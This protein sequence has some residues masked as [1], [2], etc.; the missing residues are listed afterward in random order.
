MV[1]LIGAF[2]LLKGILCFAVGFGALKLLHRDVASEIQNWVQLWQVDPGNRYVQ[3]LVRKVSHIDSRS[4]ALMSAATI[5]YAGLFTT[6]GV[7]L[8]MRK[9]WAEILTV[10]A[11]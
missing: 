9:P 11:T 6:E 5:F 4:V 8:L 1:R 2:R 10:I 7:G 3:A